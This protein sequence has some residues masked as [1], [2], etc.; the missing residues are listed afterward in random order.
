MAI[1][2]SGTEK[3]LIFFGKKNPVPQLPCRCRLSHQ[4]WWNCLNR[5]K[6]RPQRKMEY[7]FLQVYLLP[8][9]HSPAGFSKTDLAELKK[10][11]KIFHGRFLHSTHSS[12]KKYL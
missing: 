4:S 3:N 2:P 10:T 6:S 9:A 1:D 12:T 11:H 8:Q 5:Y 7:Y